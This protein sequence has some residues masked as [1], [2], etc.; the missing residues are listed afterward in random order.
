MFPSRGADD[1]SQIPIKWDCFVL[2]MADPEVGFVARHGAGGSAVQ[3]EPNETSKWAGK[4]KI[5]FHRPHPDSVIDA[6]MLS[7]MG[8]QMRKWFGRSGESFVLEE[9]EKGVKA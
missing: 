4:G 6:V 2:A 7:S 8:K 1:I 9:K 3:F 5:V